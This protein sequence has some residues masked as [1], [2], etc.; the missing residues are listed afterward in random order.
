MDQH[1]P[2]LLIEDVL[3]DFDDIIGTYAEKICIKCGVVEFVAEDTV[4]LLIN[5]PFFDCLLYYFFIDSQ[6]K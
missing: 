3:A 1:G 5:L 2:V 4:V 6:K